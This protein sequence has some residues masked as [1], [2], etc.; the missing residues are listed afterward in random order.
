MSGMFIQCALDNLDFNED[1]KDGTTM[2]V[3]THNIYQYSAT[4]APNPT[5]IPLIKAKEKLFLSP[6]LFLRLKAIFSS[7][8]GEQQD[9]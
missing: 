6:N 1:T 3:T 9:H 8:I 4:S 7:K 2:H 5:V